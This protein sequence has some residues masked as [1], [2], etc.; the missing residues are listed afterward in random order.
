MSLPAVYFLSDAHLG[1]ESKSREAPRRKRL[2][3]FLESLTGRAETLYVVGDLFDFWFEYRTAIP[4]ELFD[5]LAAL[6]QLRESGTEIVY[7]NG[8]HDFWLGPFLREEIGVRTHD[9]ALAVTH[10]G[11]RIWLHH[12][13]GLIGGDLGYRVLRRVIR[14]PASVALYRWLHPDVGIPLAHRVS[15]LSRDAKGERPL[16]PERLWTEIAAPRFAEGFDAVAIGHFHHAYERRENGRAFF[17]LGDWMS[18]FT[19]LRLENGAFALET[20]AED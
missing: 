9:G 7:L 15:H 14:H 2:R 11:R 5:T 4:R 19:Y 20:A 16:E 6:R 10:Q 12:G 1:A 13:D 18:R 3:A 17:V 8:N